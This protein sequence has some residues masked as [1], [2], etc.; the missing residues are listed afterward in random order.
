MS[1]GGG[2]S[3]P[4]TARDD[5]RHWLTI[6]LRFS[7]MDAF[8]HVNNVLFFRFFEAVIVD[9]VLGEARLDWQ[10]GPVLPYAVDVRCHFRK[11]V[12]FPGAVDAGLRIGRLGTSSVTYAVAIFAEGD[13]DP[14]G[15]GHFIH[16][17]VDRASET[18]VPIPEPVRSVYERYV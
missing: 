10:R 18:P 3:N 9:F 13:A 12:A 17:Y 11:P 14:A 6:P 15:I 2:Y 7:D 1:D 5:Y 16:V 4:H 8:G